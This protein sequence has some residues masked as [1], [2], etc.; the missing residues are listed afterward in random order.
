M[1]NI[2]LKNI[3]KSFDGK[4]DVIKGI[5]FEINS[6]E[7]FVLVGPSGC[8]KSTLLRIIS[9]LESFDSGEIYINDELAN[10]KHPKDRNLTMVFQNY[11]L[12]PNMTVRDNILFGLD[13]K[14]VTK[15]EQEERLKQAVELVDLNGLLDRKPKNLSGGQRQRVALARAICSM[16]SI[17]LMDEPLSNLDA[18]LRAQMRSEIKRIQKRLNMT[19]VYVTHDQVEAM[20]MGDRIMVL[21]SGEIMQVGTPT[22]LYN[23]PKNVFTASF[24][25]TPQMN[26]FNVTFVMGRFII[27]NAINLTNISDNFHNI[28]AEGK[29][30]MGIRP[31]NIVLAHNKFSN[32]TATVENIEFLGN[33]TIIDFCINNTKFKCRWQGEWNL[34][35]GEKVNLYL[36]LDKAYFYD[37][38]TQNLVRSKIDNLVYKNQEG[39][40]LLVNEN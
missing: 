13:I 6:G 19:M 26:F 22:E 7:F 27:D 5:D 32:M 21:K 24:V 30:I 34:E 1:S 4:E 31:D 17:C 3:H 16:E 39:E 33:E 11:A 29:Y 14:G 40:V 36:D 20:T 35:I 37:K 8:G 38:E 18:K 23:T 2:K 10:D 28:P 15:Q 25:G 12:Y 9:G